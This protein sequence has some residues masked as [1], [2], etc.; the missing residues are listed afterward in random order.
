MAEIQMMFVKQKGRLTSSDA[1]AFRSDVSASQILFIWI[2]HAVFLQTFY[3]KSAHFHDN[4]L[5]TSTQYI[6]ASV[7]CAH[8]S[9]SRQITSQSILREVSKSDR[10]RAEAKKQRWQCSGFCIFWP[11]GYKCLCCISISTIIKDREPTQTSGA[12][13]GD[14][15]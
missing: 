14:C 8:T 10:D 7:A 12:M 4:K 3:G 6:L 2:K 13:G 5:L 11:T 9:L 1:L 15:N